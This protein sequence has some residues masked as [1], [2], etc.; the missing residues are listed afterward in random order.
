MANPDRRPGKYGR[1]P[2]RPGVYTPKAE[3]YLLPWEGPLAHPYTRPDVASPT[4]YLP[5]AKGTIDRA[6]LVTDWH[7][8][9]NG[10]DPANPSY[11]PDGLGDCT[12][13]ESAHAFTALC[14]YSGQPAPVFSSDAI[15]TAY[16]ACG[17]YQQGNASTDNGCVITDVLAYMKSTGLPD[18]TGK[19]HK[20][21]AYAT[22]DP[23]NRPLHAQ[24]LSTFGTI[25]YGGLVQQA[26]E[27]QFGSGQPWQWVSGSPIAGGHA[28]GQQLRG[29]GYTGVNG[30]TTW[31]ELQPATNWFLWNSL[32]P[33]QDGE[34]FIVISEDW[35]TA[36]GTSVQGFDLQ[37]LLQDMTDVSGQ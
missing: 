21:A 35:L 27:D 13:A 33:G 25:Y 4:P 9:V 8:Y 10:P 7:M 34:A 32:D 5:P 36:N 37:Q 3:Q 22:V 29:V 18:E 17:G 23:R 26:Q 11:A 24:V 14:A 20:F 2:P 31:G 19:V 28:F 16:S 12:I 1:K 30:L 6:S 15:V